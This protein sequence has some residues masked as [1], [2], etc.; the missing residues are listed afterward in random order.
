MTRTLL[1]P[2]VL[3]TLL[4]GCSG[5]E[6]ERGAAPQVG[7]AVGDL[8]PA[9]EGTIAGGER[10]ALADM[11]GSRALL[12]FYRGGYCGLCRERLRRLQDHRAAYEELQV[13]LVAL[14][15]DSLAAILETRELTGSEF[16]IVSVDSATLS[17]WELYDPEHRAPRSATLIVDGDGVI[18]FR[19]VGRNPADQVS[20]PALIATFEQ[21]RDK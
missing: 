17:R 16:P 15:A 11:Q 8:A 1:A 20:D 5:D 3:L 7:T 19:Q 18:R 4:A 14:T 2:V 12:V 10:F 13:Q 6:S 21:L 9:L